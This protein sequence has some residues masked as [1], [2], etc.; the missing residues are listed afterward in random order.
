MRPDFFGIHSFP[1]PP[2]SGNHTFILAATDYF[3]KSSPVDV[4]AG[5]EKDQEA[6]STHRTQVYR[7]WELLGVCYARTGDRRLAFDAFVQ[8]I[9][10]Y[11]FENEDPLC[12]FELPP[13]LAIAVDRL[14]H[15]A[16]VDLRLAPAEASLLTPL[17]AAVWACDRGW[18]NV[19]FA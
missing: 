4:T 5:S 12:D 14:T 9:T 18:A 8:G 16:V 11:P 10:T 1:H 6:W 2:P 13:S 17:R 3:S 15:L 19:A 7:R